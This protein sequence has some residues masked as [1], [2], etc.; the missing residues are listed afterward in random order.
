MWIAAV[1]SG[2]YLKSISL[3][4]SIVSAKANPIVSNIT[5]YWMDQ[6]LDSTWGAAPVGAGKQIC[7]VPECIGL[8]GGSAYGLTRTDSRMNWDLGLDTNRSSL[9]A[10]N[11]SMFN[12]TNSSNVVA[13]SGV[14]FQCAVN[15]VSPSAR[16]GSI[17]VSACR[18]PAHH[19]PSLWKDAEHSVKITVCLNY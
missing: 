9:S 4:P 13:F 15:V 14:L 17:E 2:Y 10:V 11:M 5:P 12:G 8:K 16:E 1:S 6:P 7:Q 18:F 19:L 3:G